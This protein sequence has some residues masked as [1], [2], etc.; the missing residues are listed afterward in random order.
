MVHSDVRRDARVLNPSAGFDR[1]AR[2]SHAAS[3][4]GAPGLARQPAP[5]RQPAPD[6]DLARLLR[7]CVEDGGSRVA[8]APASH[9]GATRT[10]ARLIYNPNNARLTVPESYGNR[11]GRW[12]D[13]EVKGGTAKDSDP[14]LA[15]L[16]G[17][18]E[19][20]RGHFVRGMHVNRL[21]KLNVVSDQDLRAH[22][23][24]L[25][26]PGNDQVATAAALMDAV[27]AP[28][29]SLHHSHGTKYKT[30]ADLELSGSCPSPAASCRARWTCRAPM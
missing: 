1:R 30:V 12:E 20:F 6:D 23:A 19:T 10:L 3:A 24:T 13:G 8:P 17:S 21:T 4:S 27:V 29:S 9:G 22:A 18:D 26:A 28:T 14:T 15:A 7:R 5:T 25:A 2:R 16:V 11:K